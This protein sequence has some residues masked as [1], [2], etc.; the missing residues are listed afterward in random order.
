MRG[1]PAFIMGLLLLFSLAGATIEKTVSDASAQ[2]QDTVIITRNEDVLSGVMRLNGTDVP[3]TDVRESNGFIAFTTTFPV[4]LAS[5]LRTPAARPRPDTEGDRVAKPKGQ[6]EAAADRARTDFGE[7]L[8]E[9]RQVRTTETT[10]TLAS[11]PANPAPGLQ[12]PP[13]PP[14]QRYGVRNRNSR[15]TLRMH[16]P[17]HVVVQGTR[18]QIF[19]DRSL[20][21]GDSYRVPNMVGLRLSTPDA[22]AIEIILDGSFVGFAGEDGVAARG[23]SLNPQNI[24]DRQQRS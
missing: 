22:G 19:L 13:S 6:P 20:S 11:I 14:G 15:I 12:V 5:V 16:R 1:A 3:L 21:P 4:S 10:A 24:V 23:L 17:T 18:D 9:P 7:P 2:R 8:P